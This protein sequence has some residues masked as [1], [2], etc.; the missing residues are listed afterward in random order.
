MNLSLCREFS[1]EGTFITFTSQKRGHFVLWCH[2]VQTGLVLGSMTVRT[3]SCTIRM[4]AIMCLFF[5]LFV[6]VE[7]GW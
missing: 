3:E 2:P 1:P 6:C 7:W 4:P 5:V